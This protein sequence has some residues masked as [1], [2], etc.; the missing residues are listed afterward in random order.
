MNRTRHLGQHPPEY[1]L[2]GRPGEGRL[3]RQHLV[4]HAA[5]GVDIRPGIQIPFSGSL[6]GTHVGRRPHRHPRLGQG[7]PSSADRTGDP[8]IGDQGATIAGQQDVLGL[9]V[10]VDDAMLVGV[11]EG[12][13]RLP[14][15][16][17]RI[18]HRKLFLSGEPVAEALALDI[19]H[20]KPQLTR[21]FPRVVNRE[22]VGMLQP[23]DQPDLALEPF[24]TKSDG[25]LGMQD[26]QRHRSLVPDVLREVDRGH[27]T[28]TEL[29]LDPVAVS[30]RLVQRLRLGQRWTPVG[31][32]DGTTG[33]LAR[34]RE[35]GRPCKRC[36]GPAGRVRTQPS[37]SQDTTQS[38]APRGTP[39]ARPKGLMPG[40]R[41]PL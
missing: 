21:R 41:C 39:Q 26:L 13:R 36:G 19:R 23:G 10:A 32:C 31:K 27:P 28:A 29:P 12:Q 16:A 1:R 4:E 30:Q 8:E 22:D 25:E 6:L 35:R 17:Q 5:E 2:R 14:R 33:K 24:G 37:S 40:Q 20:R 3:T 11:L 7:L 9:D 18:L 15:D 38:R 34:A